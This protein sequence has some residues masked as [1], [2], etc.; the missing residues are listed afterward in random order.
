MKQKYERMIFIL[1][2]VKNLNKYKSKNNFVGPI[3]IIM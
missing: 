2:Y 1:K 3:K